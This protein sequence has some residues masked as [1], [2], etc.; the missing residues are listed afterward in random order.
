MWMVLSLVVF[1]VNV[2]VMGR[3][4]KMQ[5]RVSRLGCSLW[6]EMGVGDMDGIWDMEGEGVDVGYMYMVSGCYQY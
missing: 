1:C 6:G 2:E 4:V 3:Q 5:V